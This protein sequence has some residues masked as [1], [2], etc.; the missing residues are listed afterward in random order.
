MPATTEDVVPIGVTDTTTAIA[1][2]IRAEVT[3]WTD[4]DLGCVFM[5]PLM[6]VRTRP[7]LP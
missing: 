2:A 5:I 3:M 4:L 1:A 6:L 7:T